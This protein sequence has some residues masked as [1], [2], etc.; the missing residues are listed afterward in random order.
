MSGQKRHRRD[1]GFPNH[2][3]INLILRSV[4]WEVEPDLASTEIKKKKDLKN[5]MYMN[6]CLYVYMCTRC[7][8]GALGGQK[9]TSDPL[10]LELQV[11]VSYPVDSGN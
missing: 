6:V 8:D 5:F 10:V 4:G 3:R 7:M 11:V 9:R 1:L 2:K